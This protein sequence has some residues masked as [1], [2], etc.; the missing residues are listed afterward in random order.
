MKHLIWFLIVF[1]AMPYC[2][3]GAPKRYIIKNE[4]TG[5]SFAPVREDGLLG[6]L[7]PEYGLPEREVL[8]DDVPENEKTRILSRRE[9]GN[10]AT[11][12]QE[13]CL[14]KAQFSVVEE[15]VTAEL[16]ERDRKTKAKKDRDDSLKSLHAKAKA[17]TLTAADRN[18]IIRLMILDKFPE[19]D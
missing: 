6:P 7:Q 3:F 10:A 16:S 2:A 5:I 4:L 15:D 13:F 18:E 19:L 8:C 12:V 9:S 14:V 1:V 11:G 17:G